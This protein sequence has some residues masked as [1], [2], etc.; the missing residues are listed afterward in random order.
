VTGRT[1]FGRLATEGLDIGVLGVAFGGTGA[2]LIKCEKTAHVSIV[3][4][5]ELNGNIFL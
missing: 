5:I 3:F 2:W 4:M 1:R